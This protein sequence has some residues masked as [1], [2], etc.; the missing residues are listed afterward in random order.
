MME[1]KVYELMVNEEFK[2][3]APPLAESETENLREDILEHGCLAPII[4][5]N[6]TI[7]DGHNRYG[8]CRENNIPFAVTEIEFNDESD[9]KLWIVKNQLGRR[10]LTKFQR[11]EMV[12]PM[13]EKIKTENEMKRRALISEYQQRGE[14]APKMAES[15]DTRDALAKL[16]GVGHSLLDMAR[17]VIK[18]ADEETKEKLR[19]DEMKINAVYRT[20]KQEKKEEKNTANTDEPKPTNTEGPAI[21][22]DE[23][24]ILSNP[25]EET[26]EVF[27]PEDF[28][29]IEEQ[30]E[31]CIQDFMMN[32]RQT[33]TWI[34]K[35]HR[36]GKNEAAVKALLREG[37]DA[38]VSA[39]SDRFEELKG[40]SK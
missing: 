20:L 34:G 36:S 24:I 29:V 27:S 19:H 23:P 4:V 10:N 22:V 17:V 35:H 16:A 18:L 33:M 30:V 37:Y 11:C 40:D 15:I 25:L 12:L 3:I 7:V 21:S 28:A 5:W 8:I 31:T 13:E 9:A 2:R 38:A 39:L 6:G 14:T 26:E 1:K 32:F